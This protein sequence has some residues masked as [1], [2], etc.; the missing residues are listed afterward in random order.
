M[1]DSELV[2]QDHQEDIEEQHI[3]T[4]TPNGD[5]GA[6]VETAKYKL[7][8]KE[9]ALMLTIGELLF[10]PFFVPLW[11]A[12]IW[13]GDKCG[14]LDGGS[15]VNNSSEASNNVPANGPNIHVDPAFA[16]NDGQQRE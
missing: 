11:L 15:F 5:Q 4:D 7:T 10:V 2:G 14:I 16:V 8:G 9:L 6:L 12:M 13:L 3:D 1:S